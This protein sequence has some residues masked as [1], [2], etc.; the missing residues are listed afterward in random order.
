M[1]LL[2]YMCALY[3]TPKKAF[4]SWSRPL[5]SDIWNQQEVPSRVVV[6]FDAGITE[7]VVTT[8][9][10]KNQ[11]MT[12]TQMREYLPSI[13]STA[14]RC[15]VRG[16][17]SHHLA[18]LLWVFDSI[19]TSFSSSTRPTKRIVV[20]ASSKNSASQNET[21]PRKTQNK[22]GLRNACLTE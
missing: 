14:V 20:A 13:R 5:T 6:A 10:T 2:H 3:A 4:D 22:M 11:T 9:K 16:R 21:I 15:L 8:D 7:M 17:T 19:V 1:P 12:T 18:S